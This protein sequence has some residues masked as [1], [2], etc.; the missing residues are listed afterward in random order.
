MR[1]TSIVLAVFGAVWGAWC[2]LSA[3]H[4][5]RILAASPSP[6]EYPSRLGTLRVS[7]LATGLEHPWALAFLPDGRMLVTERPGHLLLLAG[8]GAPAVEISGLPKPFVQGQAGLLDI[9]LSPGF[10]DDPWVY[11][12]FAEGNQRG[13]LAGTAVARGRLEGH[14]LRDVEVIYRQLPKLSN[15]T[16]L[17]A[18][19]VFDDA[20]YLFVTQGDNDRRPTAQELD[21]LQGKLVRIAAD[22]GI[23]KD[24]PFV[25]RAGARPEIWSYGHRNMQGAAINPTTRELWTTEHGPMGGDEI[26]IPQAGKNYGWPIITWGINYSGQ[27]IPEATGTAAE[28]MEQ[29]HYYWKISPAISGMAFYTADRIPAWRQSL[30]VGALAKTCLIRLELE[31]DRIVAE[32]RLLSERKERIRDVRVGPDGLL[33]LLTDD[34]GGKLLRVEMKPNEP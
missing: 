26:N 29:P 30:F 1:A 34:A 31:G 13:N 2:D 33:Y 4:A 23:P 27:P 15:G 5:E 8:D 19:L 21:K 11:L 12:A 28:G 22:G 18:R 3:A 17:G 32:E 25:G 7:E 20:G 24:N 10:A 16:H 6:L 9:A 14:A